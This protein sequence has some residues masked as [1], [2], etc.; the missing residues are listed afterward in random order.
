MDLKFSYSLSKKKE[1]LDEKT[2]YIEMENDLNR[3]KDLE[4]QAG[5]PLSGPQKNMKL[6]FFLMERIPGFFVS[7][8]QQ[9]LYLLSLICSGLDQAPEA[10]LFLDDVLLELDKKNQENFLDFLS[11]T[12]NQVFLTH[13]NKPDFNVKKASHFHV[14]QRHN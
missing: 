1:A 5:V 7:K 13:C 8:G 12:P 10:L 3:K 14:K 6:F 2:L 9:R 11:E 4:V